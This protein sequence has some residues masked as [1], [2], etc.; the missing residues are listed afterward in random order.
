MLQMELVR[1]PKGKLSYPDPLK[2][3]MFRHIHETMAP[4][5]GRVFT[6]LCMEKAEIWLSTFGSVYGSNEEFEQDFG[7]KVL[8]KLFPAT[9]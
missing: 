8:G 2:Q 7:R 5:H 1:G 4:W 6:Y 3:D 9:P